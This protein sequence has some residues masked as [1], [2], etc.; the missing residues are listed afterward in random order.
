MDYNYQ[1]LQTL[2]NSNC[3]NNHLKLFLLSSNGASGRR[4]VPRRVHS[5]LSEQDRR[6]YARS[7]STD[8]ARVDLDHLTGDR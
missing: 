4:G 2:G 3:I 7:R 5:A 1:Q 6:N 8:R